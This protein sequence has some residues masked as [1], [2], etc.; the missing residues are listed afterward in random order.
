MKLKLCFIKSVTVFLIITVKAVNADSLNLFVRKSRDR[1]E[2]CFPRQCATNLC[3]YKLVVRSSNRHMWIFF[4][5]VVLWC[6]FS[7]LMFIRLAGSFP[8]CSLTIFVLLF[9]HLNYFI[10]LSW[11]AGRLSQAV[12]SHS[13]A[14]VKL[15]TGRVKVQGEWRSEPGWEPKFLYSLSKALIP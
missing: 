13:A 3:R 14:I 8:S 5:L 7:F 2:N 15:L 9:F 6:F 4:W 11:K 1:P 12:I 10:S